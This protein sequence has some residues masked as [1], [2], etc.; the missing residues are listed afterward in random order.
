MLTNSLRRATRYILERVFIDG[1]LAF[2]DFVYLHGTTCG[3]DIALSMTF[4][5]EL[6]HCIQ[7]ADRTSLADA[8]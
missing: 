5:H 8:S 7:H 6:Q 3:E 1:P 2:D 4:A